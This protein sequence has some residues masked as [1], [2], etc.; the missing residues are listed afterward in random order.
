MTKAQVSFTFYDE[1]HLQSFAV[2]TGDL[3]SMTADW[4]LKTLETFFSSKRFENLNPFKIFFHHYPKRFAQHIFFLSG[5]GQ[6][7]GRL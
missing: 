6:P 3:S 7:Q 1:N 2:S 4:R 5:R